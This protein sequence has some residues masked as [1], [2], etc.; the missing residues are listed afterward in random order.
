MICYMWKH[1]QQEAFALHNGRKNMPTPLGCI[2]ATNSPGVET[3][4]RHIKNSSAPKR[5]E[6]N[7]DEYV[8]EAADDFDEA[9]KDVEEDSRRFGLGVEFLRHVKFLRMV[10]G[11][12]PQPCGVSVQGILHLIGGNRKEEKMT[13]RCDSEMEFTMPVV[14]WP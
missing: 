6:D 13:I 8:E 7:F 4:K 12:W 2:T 14:N 11:S 9:T 3:V 5:G 1:Q 10:V